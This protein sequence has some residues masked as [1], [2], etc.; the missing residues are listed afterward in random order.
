MHTDVFIWGKKVSRDFRNK[1]VKICY[2]LEIE[3]N[4]LMACIAFETGE[5]FSPSI[6]NKLSKATGL[7]QFMPRTAKSLGT[8]IEELK[9]MTAVDQLTWVYKYF[10]PYK[11]KIKSLED[12][13]MAILYPAGIGKPPDYAIF[14]SPSIF[15]S[16]NSGLDSNNDGIVTKSETCAKIWQKFEK[17]MRPEYC[18]IST[19]YVIKTKEL[20]DEIRDKSFS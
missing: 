20:A 1:I 10:K 14:T 5:T 4:W 13:Y 7:I 17:G 15:Y 8:T 19:E 9:Q 2:E 3:V 16:Q 18:Y 6:Q 11:G 12:C